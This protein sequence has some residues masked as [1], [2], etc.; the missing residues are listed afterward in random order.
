MDLATE[1]GCQYQRLGVYLQMRQST[2]DQIRHDHPNDIR[3]QLFELLKL[4][5]QREGG[6]HDELTSLAKL[7]DALIKMERR[8]LVDKYIDMN[9]IVTA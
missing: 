3:T 1:L 9:T 6:G 5:V 8:D 7:R 2:I 4:W